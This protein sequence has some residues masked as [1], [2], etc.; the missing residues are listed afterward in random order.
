LTDEQK[1]KLD[2]MF[3]N[4]MGRNQ[5]G[6][7]GGDTPTR[8]RRRRG[9]TVEQRVDRAMEELAIDDEEEAAAIRALVEKVVKAQDELRESGRASRDRVR[10]L[11]A[12]DEV[13]NEEI[14]ALLEEIRKTRGDL[15]NV[16]EDARKE[17]REVI[18]YRQE[19]T[20]VSL[21]ILD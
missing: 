18:S 8:E 21:G 15:E 14:Q 16:M 1:E 7:Q 3:Q 11:A 2:E 12:K 13:E 19:L 4:P 20:L 9:P 5:R 17:L 6:G 10:E